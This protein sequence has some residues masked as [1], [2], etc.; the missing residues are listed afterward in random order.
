MKE[1]PVPFEEKPW[2]PA[3]ELNT[4]SLSL[5]LPQRDL[6]SLT[7]VTVDIHGFSRMTFRSP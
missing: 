7:R 4:V 1:R 6:Q 2:Y 3:Q 5:Y